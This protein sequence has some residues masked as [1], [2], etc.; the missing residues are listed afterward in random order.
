M[1]T[2]YELIRSGL[3]YNKFEIGPLIFVEYTCPIEEQQLGIWTPSDYMIHILS[4]KKGWRTI[5]HAWTAEAGETFY[6]K[7]GAYII[8]QYFEE[9]FCMLL[10]FISND[11]IR[12][13]VKQI[14]ANSKP[15]GQHSA[16]NSPVIE[17]NNDLTLTTYFQSM[18]TYFTRKEKPSDSLLILKLRELIF[19]I[20]QSAANPELAAYFSLMEHARTPSLNEIVNNNFC[21]NL[22]L[23]D[24]AGMCGC[25]LST[26]KR[27]FKKQFSISP[28][29]WLRRKKLEYA[30]ALL[31]T[32][33]FNI[34]QICLECGFE[35]LAHF[36]R[37][38][39]TEMNTTP[40]EYREQFK[41]K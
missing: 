24:Y 32:T 40:S 16:R 38:F 10:F 21:Y 29:M 13:S 39:K 9:E 19:N 11:F 3:H 33:D 37:L 18:L 20:M 15:A 30:A 41:S 28:G 22:Q 34:S 27:E 31:S 2:V 36:S 4:G 6:I 12:D 8:E 7:K 14:T 1:I 26:F 23:N 35:N 25:S 17:I 5:N